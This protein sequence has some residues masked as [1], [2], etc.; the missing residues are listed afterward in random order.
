MTAI[1]GRGV[2][3]VDFVERHARTVGGHFGM[4][5]AAVGEHILGGGFGIF[6][7]GFCTL[8]EVSQLRKSMDSVMRRVASCVLRVAAGQ[9]QVC[10]SLAERRGYEDVE[11]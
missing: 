10:P 3:T 4:L 8:E 11:G 5:Q 7:G 2:V 6:G 9:G 1:A